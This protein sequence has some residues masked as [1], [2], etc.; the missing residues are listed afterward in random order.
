M[1]N[2]TLTDLIAKVRKITARPSFNQITD[3][4]ITDY[5]NLFYEFDFPQ[6]LRVFDL[7]TTY[8]FITQPNIDQYAL[9]AANRNLY[10]SFEPPV[11]CSGYLMNYFQSRESFYS[12]YPNLSTTMTFATSTGVAGPYTGTLSQ[13]SVL[14]N[15]I[16]ISV[17]GGGGVILTAQD[18][19]LGTFTGDVVAGGTINYTT[20]AVSL[21]FNAL[22]P[23]GNLITARWAVYQSAQPQSVLFY[24]N[25]FTLRPVPDQA[26]EIETQAF[27]TPTAY[28]STVG[29]AVPLVAD[30]FQALAYGAARK[31]FIDSLDV[32]GVSK[33]QPFLDEQIAF[34]ERKT[35]MQIKTQRTQTIFSDNISTVRL[36]TF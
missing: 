2:V 10:K 18:N 1:A 6:S 13:L 26:Y 21:T 35:M 14:R 25:T 36:P 24:D 5:I 8:S 27:L 20:G 31:I 17:D 16:L 23:A 34:C 7:R 9:S 28:M 33:I 19:G 32:D 12:N 15:S 11:Y 22:I 4:Q 3:P 30:Y 29:T